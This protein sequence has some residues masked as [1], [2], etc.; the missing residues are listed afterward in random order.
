[1]VCLTTIALTVV[2]FQGNYPVTLALSILLAMT[3]MALNPL[4]AAFVIEIS[5][6][7][8]PASSLGVLEIFNGLLSASVGF[9]IMPFLLKVGP[10]W[11]MIF[12]SVSSI[13]GVGLSIFLTEDL[14]RTRFAE[15]RRRA[16]LEVEEVEN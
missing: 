13:I 14:K 7:I 8:S 15:L 16:P 1:M 11:F 12:L 6:P 10:F 9:G 4:L 5:Y 2:F 3:N